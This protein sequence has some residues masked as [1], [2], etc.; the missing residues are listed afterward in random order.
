VAES[1]L[2]RL[3]VAKQQA[4]IRPRSAPELCTEKAL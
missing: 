3:H 4:G 2:P 1:I